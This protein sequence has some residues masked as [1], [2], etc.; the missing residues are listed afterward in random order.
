MR[1]ALNKTRVAPQSKIFLIR[2]HTS[3]PPATEKHRRKNRMLKEGRY[4]VALVQES[5]HLTI[6]GWFTEVFFSFFY[7]SR[8]CGRRASRNCCDHR[9]T[10]LD[11]FFRYMLDTIN[12]RVLRVFNRTAGFFTPVQVFQSA[13]WIVSKRFSNT[14]R[15]PQNRN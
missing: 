11:F 15:R 7:P 9:N 4:P 2:V 6:Y 14:R 1:F 8:I 5:I 3:F 12:P 13:E 10:W